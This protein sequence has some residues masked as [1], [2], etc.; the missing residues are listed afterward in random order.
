MN[1]SRSFGL[2]VAWGVASVMLFSAAIANHPY[3]FYTLLRWVCC[4]V[5]AYSAAF[6]LETQRVPWAWIFGVLAVVYNPLVPVHLDR[7][8]WIAVNWFTIGV[9]A[10][11]AV[12]FWR[13]RKDN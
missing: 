7:G 6:A 8:T 12:L 2:Y 5:F 11:A 3:S 10:V 13:E 9:I 1:N 4:P